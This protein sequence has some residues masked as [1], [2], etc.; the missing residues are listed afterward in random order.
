VL[1]KQLN[2]WRKQLSGAPAVL[3]LP[4]DR[5][6]PMVESFQ[7]AVHSFTIAAEVA[8]Q[9]RVLARK[10]QATLFMTLLA[11]WKVLLHRYT[12]QEDIVVEPPIANRNREEIEN[13]IGFFVNTLVL[14]GT[15][16]GIHVLPNC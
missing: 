13:L 11:I 12:G 7:G 8:E 1:E 16:V 14:R 4:T 15:W 10:H 2:Y 6:R 5:P 9:L 3:E